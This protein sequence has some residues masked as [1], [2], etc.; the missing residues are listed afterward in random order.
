MLFKKKT[1]LAKA[2]AAWLSQNESSASRKSLSEYLP[3]GD[4]GLVTTASEAKLVCSAIDKARSIVGDSEDWAAGH[5]LHAA[6]ALLQ[7]VGSA[8]AQEAFTQHGLPRLRMIVRERIANPKQQHALFALKIIGYYGQADD[9]ELFSAAVRAP[10]DP[11][12]FWWQPAFY[13]FTADNPCTPAFIASLADPL[14]PGFIRVVFLDKCNELAAAAHLQVHPFAS[15]DGIRTLED[16][17][18]SGKEDEFSYAVSACAALPFI[19]SPS[20]E[21]LIELASAH[22]SAHVR[23][24]AAWSRAKLGMESGAQAL[25]DFARDARYSSRATAY[26]KEVGLEARIPEEATRPDF[27]ALAGMCD[28]LAHPNEMGRPPDRITLVDSR[29]LYWPPTRDR[30]WLWIFRY[31]YESNE[32]EPD[33]G[34]CMTGSVTWAMF[35]TNTLDLSVED[36]YGLH[37]AWELIQAEDG[38]APGDTDAAAGRAILS[39]YN[40][41]FGKPSLNVVGSSV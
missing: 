4:A 36:V 23:M 40:P 21:R 11:A 18:T 7:Q 16:W 9:V 34:Y 39:K 14:P 17:L 24:E 19:P 25:I 35:G 30:R 32:A 13:G 12:S 20:R 5:D 26:M 1:A 22:P 38:E 28:W 27:V 2:L 37:C 31:R 29:E 10:I 15:S 6:I 33:E 3:Q 41:E 8:E